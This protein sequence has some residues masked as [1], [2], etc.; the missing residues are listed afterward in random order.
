MGCRSGALQSL[1]VRDGR[2]PSRCPGRRPR[3]CVVALEFF[4]SFLFFL[5]IFLPRLDPG[6]EIFFFFSP[7]G[8]LEPRLSASRWTQ[9][10]QEACVRAPRSPDLILSFPPQLCAL[11]SLQSVQLSSGWGPAGPGSLKASPAGSPRGTPKMP[12]HRALL[13]TKELGSRA[14]RRFEPRAGRP[15][16][17][18][19]GKGGLGSRLPALHAPLSPT[20]CFGVPPAAGVPAGSGSACGSLG[21]LTYPVSTCLLS[22]GEIGFS[23]LL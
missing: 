8:S 21:A 14:Q 18:R 13:K 3:L 23:F 20:G 9:D 19:Q 22:G 6:S 5:Q 17:A 4:L 11:Q 15:K 7:L 10:T 1:G 2:P 16:P 12:L